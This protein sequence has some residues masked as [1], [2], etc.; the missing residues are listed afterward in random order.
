MKVK[1][2]C[3]KLAQLVLASCASAKMK[4]PGVPHYKQKDESFLMQKVQLL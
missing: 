1:M 2:D 3:G 4:T